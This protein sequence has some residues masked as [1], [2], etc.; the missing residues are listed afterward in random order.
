MRVEELKRLVVTAFSV[1]LHTLFVI[2]SYSSGLSMLSAFVNP[3]LVHRVLMLLQ[4]APLIVVLS[5]R[6]LLMNRGLLFLAFSICVHTLSVVHDFYSGFYGSIIDYESGLMPRMRASATLMA[7]RDSGRIAVLDPHAEYFLEYVAVHFLSEITGMNHVLVYA[8]SMRMIHIAFFAS[9]FTIACSS[10]SLKTRSHLWLLL[11][12]ATLLTANR[13]YSSEMSFGPLMLFMLFLLMTKE[14]RLNNNV[15]IILVALATLF[16]SLRETLILATISTVAILVSLVFLRKLYQPFALTLAVLG[17]ARAL[18]FTSTHYIKSYAIY[19]FEI[20]EAIWRALVEGLSLEKF[21]LS[22]AFTVLNPVDRAIALVSSISFIALL[23]ALA[24]MS[25]I[26][27]ARCRPT[28]HVLRAAP[29]AYVLLY[30]IPVAQYVA[31]NLMQG[32][33]F[34]FEASTVLIKSPAPV[35]ALVLAICSHSSREN[36][37]GSTKSRDMRPLAR[38]ALLTALAIVLS[39]APLAFSHTYMYGSEVRS[40]YDALRVE[41]PSG[42]TI[43][44][45]RLYDFV[46]TYRVPGS[47]VVLDR[48]SLFLYHFYKL[49]LEYATGGLVKLGSSPAADVIYSNRM[50]SASVRGNEIL[51][52][53]R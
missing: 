4:F 8:S 14:W 17:L 49:P 18:L 38:I 34:D 41:D 36:T 13:P 22:A 2:F 48:S 12:A 50:F 46:V 39:F 51:L 26:Y 19:F 11:L 35:V 37:V 33:G 5:D 32:I 21:P 52:E 16:A 1:L 15:C 9:L 40:C 10:I 43:G 28:R 24:L 45:N 42:I 47:I 20:I 6:K 23:A 7:Y 29:L 3:L 44:G 53:G 27:T 25:L 30:A 31:V